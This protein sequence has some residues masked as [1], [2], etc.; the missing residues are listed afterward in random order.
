[1]KIDLGGLTYP[2][3]LNCDAEMT[4]DHQCGDMKSDS[5]WEDVDSD[6]KDVNSEN[7]LYPT[8]DLDCENWADKFKASIHRYHGANP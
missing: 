2:P 6:W 3:S 5:D 4:F 8:I 1:M 7:N